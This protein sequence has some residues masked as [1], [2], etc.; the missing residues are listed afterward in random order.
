MKAKSTSVVKKHDLTIRVE[1]VQSVYL[2][3]KYVGNLAR[4]PHAGIVRFIFLKPIESINFPIG[5]SDEQVL[6]GI[7]EKM[8]E[9]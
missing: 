4:Y 3:K 1:G 7:W 6:D 8:N 9:G 2:R 5:Y